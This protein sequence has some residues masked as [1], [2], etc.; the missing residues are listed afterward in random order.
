MSLKCVMN[1][2]GTLASCGASGRGAC[3]LDRQRPEARDAER[4]RQRAERVAKLVA[5]HDR[6]DPLVRPLLEDVACRL[7]GSGGKVLTSRPHPH[8]EKSVSWYTK[9]LE[10]GPHQPYV[11]VVLTVSLFDPPAYVIHEYMLKMVAVGW[12][13]LGTALVGSWGDMAPVTRKVR[14]I[15]EASLRAALIECIAA[16]AEH[17]WRGNVP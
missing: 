12:F 5:L 13:W 9:G 10:K 4:K 15:D 16:L 2:G 1:L 14:P 17:N 3:A 11:E 7:Y 8:D 6:Y